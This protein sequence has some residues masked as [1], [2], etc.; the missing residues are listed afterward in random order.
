MPTWTVILLVLAG[1]F[2]LA[3]AIFNWDWFMTH[4]RAAIFVRFLG[5]GGARF[6]YAV[7]GLFLAGVGLAG[8]FGFI[9]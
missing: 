7:L 6:F 3:G 1:L 5:R 2:S 8:A 9:R 4:R